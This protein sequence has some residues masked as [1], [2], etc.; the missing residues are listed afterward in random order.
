MK[1]CSIHIDGAYL[2]HIA[3]K[4]FGLNR[5][6]IVD[7]AN[8]ILDAFESLV[9]MDLYR[10]YYYNSLPYIDD[11]SSEAEHAGHAAAQKFLDA[12]SLSPRCT[13]R[14]GRLRRQDNGSFVQRGIDVQMT[15]DILNC[16]HNPDIGAM[17]LLTGNGDILPAVESAQTHGKL[18]MLAFHDKSASSE[19][20]M[21]VDERL[22]F[23][24]SGKQVLREIK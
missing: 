11:H 15:V 13:V 20:R 12:V 21:V 6:S 17:I 22:V 8:A 3:Q 24:K 4:E 7:T 16:A 14:L 23:D 5:V 18:V 1:F 10:I 19:L 2:S 9:D